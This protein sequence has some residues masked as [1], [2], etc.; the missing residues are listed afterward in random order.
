VSR[1]TD[2]SRK[3]HDLT[4]FTT[5]H[6]S[7][8]RCNAGHRGVLGRVG[9]KIYRKITRRCAIVMTN[10]QR[11]GV[12]GGTTR[13]WREVAGG[14]ALNVWFGSEMHA[15]VARYI[16][17]RER[18]FVSRCAAMVEGSAGDVANVARRAAESLAIRLGSTK[19][20]V[21]KTR[22]RG[23]R[24]AASDKFPGGGVGVESGMGPPLAQPSHDLTFFDNSSPRIADG[25]AP[26]RVLAPKP[27]R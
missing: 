9:R 27:L 13:R 6:R 1:L 3:L 17:F 5:L 4:A 15:D 23:I 18:R 11:R 26:A 10:A 22:E 14:E 7:V 20:D 25:I 24:N 12:Y 21:A 19:G 16:G 2:C 8:E